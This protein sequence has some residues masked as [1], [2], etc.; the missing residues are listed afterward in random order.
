MIVY[1]TGTGNSRWC[2]QLL[3]RQL[4]DESTDAFPCLRAGEAAALRSEKPWVFVCPTYAWQMPEVFADFLRRS[5][6]EGSREAYFIMSC[7]G[8]I[9]AAAVRNRALCAQLGLRCRGTMPVVMPDNYVVMFSAPEAAECEKIVEAARPVLEAAAERI[10]RGEAL[11][12]TRPGVLDKLKSGVVNKG[13]CRYAT[14][15]GPFRSTEACTGCGLCAERCVLGNI[16]LENGRPVWGER[17]TQCMACLC[18]CPAQAVEYGRSSVGKRRYRG[19]VP[20]EGS[21][22]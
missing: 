15:T 11:A 7:G 20:S 14:R 12:E 6:L 19:P 10:R 21:K 22:P 8:D 16:R 4:E 2:A 9:G 1:F 13:F 17:C 18:L 3:A 5:R